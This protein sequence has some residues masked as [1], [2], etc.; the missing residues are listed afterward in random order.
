[1][2]KNKTFSIVQK[3]SIL[4]SVII[5]IILI[6]TGLIS[7]SKLSEFGYKFNGEHTKT[8]VNFALNS[9]NGDSL[10]VLI[11]EKNDSASYANYLRAELKKIRDMAGMK[12]LYTFFHEKGKYLYAIEGGDQNADDYSEFGSVAQW[13]ANV[14]IPL[15][16]R[17]YNLKVISNTKIEFNKT[18]GWMVT[19]YAPILNSSGNVIAIMGCDIEAKNVVRD[20]KQFRNVLIVTGVLFLLVSIILVYYLIS[21]S[22]RV[23]SEIT[24][25]TTEL[26][27][28]NLDIKVKSITNDEFG[29]LANSVNKMIDHFKSI[30][31]TINLNSLSIINESN[32][33]K[34]NSRELAED[35]NKQASVAEE[36]STSVEQIKSNIENNTE[37]AK[38]AEKLSIS[39][40]QTLNKVVSANKTSIDSIRTINEKIAIIEEISRQTNILA[41]NAAIEAARAGEYGKGFSVVAAEVQKLAER[42]RI[43]ANEISDISNRSVDL[44]V[45]A[46]QKL[47]ALVP[48]IEETVSMI[49]NIAQASMEQNYGIDQINT[50]VIQLNDITQHN[51]Q[52]AEELS[53]A[54][55][56]L[57]KQSD[58]LKHSIAF[59]SNH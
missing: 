49:K 16:E 33:V 57:A 29:I 4:T 22:V 8:V 21:R 37:N 3:L 48:D 9:I 52:T 55:N 25:V 51:A 26:T 38:D 32:D 45:N 6:V 58:E 30:V 42:S 36:V 7:Y 27:D 44:S 54:A 46:S 39:T 43:A 20:I 13:D 15:I 10:E 56:R 28:G 18:Y 11:K 19:S 23:L 14:D 5:L 35:A 12:Y 59:F 41:L 31:S 17:C 53:N 40:S 50:A 47:E 1:M 34:V 24:Q 2:L